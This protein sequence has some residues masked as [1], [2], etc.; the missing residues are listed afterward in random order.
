[1]MM[2]RRSHTFQFCSM[3]HVYDAG[4]LSGSDKAL[5]GA[6][7]V[8]LMVGMGASLTP[9]DYARALQRPRA[10]LIGLLSQ[11]GWMPFLAYLAIR[12]F[13][14]EG[15]DALGLL[16]IA[17]TSGGNASNMFSYFSR[18]DLALS[19]SM[20]AIS[21]LVSV[22]M[23]PSLLYAYT[24]SLTQRQ[25]DVPFFAVVGTLALMLAPIAAGM[26]IRHRSVGTAKRVERVGAISGALLLVVLLITTVS[27]QLDLLLTA[28]DASLLACVFVA[29]SG[30]ILGYGVARLAGLLPR[31]RHAVSLETGVQNTPLAI[32]VILATFPDADQDA[33]LKMSFLY[34]MTALCVGTLATL[35]YR[36][37]PEA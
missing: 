17:C 3:V 11:F 37:F 4:M 13:A 10:V 16:L 7:T 6:L 34:A 8:I 22:V 30:M 21:T 32:A 25:M 27:D 36:R 15:T 14:L 33:L 18:A 35:T 19:V 29:G 12:R 5:I 23:M 31:Q 26:W 2:P 1:L 28:Q 24:A 9:A 20:T